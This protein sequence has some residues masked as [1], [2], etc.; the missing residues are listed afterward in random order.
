MNPIPNYPRYSISKDGKTVVGPKGEMKIQMNNCGYRTVQIT[1]NEK[2]HTFS[3]ARLMALTY[4]PNPDNKASIDHIN[5]IR[6]DDRLENLQWATM[7]EQCVNKTKYCSNTSGV[8]NVRMDSRRGHG[9]KRWIYQKC[10]NGKKYRKAQYTKSGAC[11]EQYCHSRLIG[12]LHCQ[13]P[14]S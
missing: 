7:L 2:K 13:S 9:E 5:R 8:R 6:T 11:F 12:L 14:S 3:I 4:I 1:N 10:I